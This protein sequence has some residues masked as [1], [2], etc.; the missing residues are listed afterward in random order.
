MI[1]YKTFKNN[2]RLVI[3]RIEG[4]LSA[5]VGVLVK[6]G[7][8]NET[9]VENGISH[10]IE[11]TLFKG[12][13]K[14]SAFDISDD[15]DKIGAQINAFTS[16]ELTCYYTKSTGE[17][18]EDSL[19]VLSDIFFNSEFLEK[20]LEKEKGVVIEEINMCEDT[21]EDV[22]LD[23]LAKT[24]H[25]D[26]GV[27]KT[28]LGPAANIKRFTKKDI[29]A[30]MD[31]YY[32]PD[33]VV[34]SI[35]G[36]VNVKNAEKLVEKYFAENFKAGKA[37]KQVKNAAFKTG[38]AHKNK[39]IEQSHFAFS[40]PAID[41]ADERADALSIANVVL[42]G[43]MSSRLFQKIREEMGLAYSVYSYCSAYKD[44]GVVEIYAGV[45]KEKRE[46]AAKAI[47]EELNKFNKS[48]ITE[49]EFLR[50]KE[51]A[52]SSFVFGQ[53][54]TAS[55]MLVCGKY[56]L[57]RDKEFDFNQ[58]IAEIEKLTLSDVNDVIKEIFQ[59]NNLAIASV[60]AGRSKIKI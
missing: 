48:G 11:H 34:I 37:A 52:K 8:A 25:G 42:G 5:S 4:L 36:N 35:A 39:K 18:L 54:S 53:E 33:N 60:D 24:S 45:N 3:N 56:L 41:M 9:D 6:T 40:M 19:E 46:D 17:H 26:V 51:Q 58:R 28:I 44:C 2:L 30:Y 50:G 1:Y 55:Q 21:P 57:F 13:K 22:C 14:R 10:F 16:K 27:G 38:V 31:K 20:E 49:N 15:I 59:T 47:V 12:T 43:G 23:L 7:S 29:L 32:T